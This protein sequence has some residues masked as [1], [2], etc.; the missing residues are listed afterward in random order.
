MAS[1]EP[2][3]YSNKFGED[4]SGE[5]SRINDIANERM[6]GVDPAVGGPCTPQSDVISGRAPGAT[7]IPTTDATLN[8]GGKDRV[9]S[10]WQP[11]IPYDATLRTM[12]GGVGSE[13]LTSGPP[14]TFGAVP[15]DC[16]RSASG[17]AMNS[18]DIFGS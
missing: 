18:K 1:R 2:E 7:P 12:A 5:Q 16:T 4:K 17:K 6:Q 15:S 9:T 11:E 13:R 8:F 14:D 3:S 10:G